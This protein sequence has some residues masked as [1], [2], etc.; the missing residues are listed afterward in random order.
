[1]E[2]CGHGAL[3]FAEKSE[4]A[5][6]IRRDVNATPRPRKLLSATWLK[7]RPQ[8]RTRSPGK[9]M[10]AFWAWGWNQFGEMGIGVADSTGCQCHSTPVQSNVGSNN[11][12]FG[13]GYRFS[14][15]AA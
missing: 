8:A 6:P 1:M 3:M 10:A 12:I 9:P 4:T 11:S 2:P 14:F 13:I 5:R 7:L 15:A